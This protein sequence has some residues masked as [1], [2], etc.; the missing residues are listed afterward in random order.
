MR[1]RTRNRTELAV[2]ASSSGRQDLVGLDRFG[3]WL[4]R[5]AELSFSQLGA[6]F[7]QVPRAARALLNEGVKDPCLGE[8][9]E[10]HLL[11]VPR[12]KPEC[13][14]ARAAPTL[15][16][17]AL[18]ALFAFLFE[19]RNEVFGGPGGGAVVKDLGA[20]TDRNS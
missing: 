5:E 3:G 9:V 18:P 8:R 10:A 17:F 20:E 6:G 16:L 13:E 7:R 11:R 14:A 1:A 4:K 19:E 15:G 12:V 2:P